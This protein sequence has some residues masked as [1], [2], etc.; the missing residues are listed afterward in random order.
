[1]D[2]F[3]LLNLLLH[4]CVILIGAGIGSFLNVVIYRLP[5]GK[6]VND[7][8]RSFCPKCEY[9]IPMYLNIPLVSWLMLRGKCANCGVRIPFRYFFVEALTGALFYLAFL[10]VTQG[11]YN[12]WPAMSQWGPVVLALWVFLAL[13]ISGTFID[14]DHFILPHEITMGGTVAGLAFAFWAPSLVGQESHLMGLTVSFLSATMGLGLI[15][16][17]VEVGKLMFGRLNFRERPAFVKSMKGVPLIG[18]L[19]DP[20]L[21][22]VMGSKWINKPSPWTLFEPNEDSPPVFAFNDGESADDETSCAW[23]DIFQREK[24]RMLVYCETLTCNFRPETNK[25]PLTWNKVIVDATMEV[26]KVRQG[27]SDKGGESIPWEGVKKLEGVLTS[28]VQPR[29]AMGMGDVFFMAMIGAFTGW[30]GV[31]FTV[32]AASIIGS[33]CALI[34]RLIGKAEW[35]AQI[36]FGPYLAAGAT[37]WIFK[38]PE[39]F[40]WYLDRAPG[41]VRLLHLG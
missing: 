27:E 7:P 24:D 2:R 20:F 14:L 32:F 40:Q 29:E 3:Q 33:I 37:L 25:A 21:G 13:L 38:G 41:L 8:K 34:P 5:I 22:M 26:L 12:P 15:W 19:L 30:Q 4:A 6:S 17:V 18:G 10:H 35:T 9:Q 11:F 1:M 36:P 23:E 39:W 31:I 16:S 28:F